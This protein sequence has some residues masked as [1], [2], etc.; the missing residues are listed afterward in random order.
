MLTPHSHINTCVAFCVLFLISLG[1]PQVFAPAPLRASR[2]L[3][4]PATSSSPAVGSGGTGNAPCWRAFPA[5][6]A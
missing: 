6:S 3:Q 1:G 5:A 4:V 2:S